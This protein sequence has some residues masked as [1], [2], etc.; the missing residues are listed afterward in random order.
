MFVIKVVDDDDCYKA[1][2][3]QSVSNNIEVNIS[4]S[5]YNDCD[6]ELGILVILRQ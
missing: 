3:L 2:H 6:D 5:L 4:H 1:L